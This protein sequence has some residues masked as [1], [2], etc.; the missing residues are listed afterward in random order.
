MGVSFTQTGGAERQSSKFGAV[1]GK[2]IMSFRYV[3]WRCP[4]DI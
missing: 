4:Q 2:L 3:S 1:V